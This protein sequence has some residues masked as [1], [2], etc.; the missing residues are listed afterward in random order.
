MPSADPLLDKAHKP[1]SLL[2]IAVEFFKLGCTSFG[3]PAVHLAM[4]QDQLVEQKNWLS[5][6]KYTEL[7][8]MASC[9]PGPSSTQ[10]AYGIGITQQGV[11]GGLLSGTMFALPG[12][13][14]LTLLGFLSHNLSAQIADENSPVNAVAIACGCVGVALVF[15]A[16]AQLTSKMATGPKLGSIC[17]TVA[18]ICIMMHPQPAWLNVACVFGGGLVTNILPNADADKA[19][20]NRQT[21]T[22][23][24]VPLAALIFVLYLAVAGWC[25]Y[26]TAQG[27]DGWFIGFLCAGMF[28]WGGGPVVLPFLM[29]VLTPKYISHT[30]FLLGIALAE[31]CPGPVFNMSC[32]LAVQLA[33]TSGESWLLSCALAWGALLGPGITLMFGA[34]PLWSQMQRFSFYNKALPGLNA[35]A[36]GLLVSTL[37]L[38]F[39]ALEKRSPWIE[40]SR[41]LVLLAWA[42]TE[43]LKLSVPWVVLVAGCAGY[44]YSQYV[45]MEKVTGG[46]P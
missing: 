43:H 19:V 33:L 31:M 27:D 32:F 15:K 34:L 29:T 23:L 39:S 41:A 20:C 5:N 1:P 36:T 35:A 26:D 12:A 37:F 40:G 8:A 44:G 11:I 28:V 21:R 14:C 18:A 10:V 6:E 7:V 4:Y 25:S 16:T 42:A 30:I 22:G 2:T 45:A 13:I 9:L 46:A 38:V 17:F 24:P 3:G